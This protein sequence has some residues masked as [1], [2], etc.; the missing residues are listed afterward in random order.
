V[1]DPRLQNARRYWQ[2][3]LEDRINAIYGFVSGDGCLA[4]RMASGAPGAIDPTEPFRE[5]AVQY[6]AR[7]LTTREAIAAEY[8]KSFFESGHLEAEYGQA[9][10]AQIKKEIE[11]RL[12]SNRQDRM[13]RQDRR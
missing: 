11:D 12:L 4:G 9:W 1:N 3:E 8:S 13:N 2:K 6:K 5:I 7:G 10:A